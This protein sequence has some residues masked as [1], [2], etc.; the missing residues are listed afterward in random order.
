MGAVWW[1]CFMLVGVL[2]GEVLMLD[3]SFP[4]SA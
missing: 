1:W 2:N 4:D 3:I